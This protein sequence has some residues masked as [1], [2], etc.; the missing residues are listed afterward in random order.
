MPDGVAET[1]YGRETMAEAVAETFF[2]QTMPDSVAETVYGRETVAEGFA[3]T[4]YID[5]APSGV[6]VDA[7]QWKWS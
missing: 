2:G 6:V 3:E 4:F 5:W 1:V 7:S